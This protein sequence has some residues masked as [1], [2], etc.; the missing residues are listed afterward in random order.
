[1]ADILGMQPASAAN[2]NSVQF[3]ACNRVHSSNINSAPP[4]I[5]A[6]IGSTLPWP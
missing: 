5:S 1:M 2:R 3:G 6:A 4:P